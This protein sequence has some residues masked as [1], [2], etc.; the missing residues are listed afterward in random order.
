MAANAISHV[1]TAV[2]LKGRPY[3]TE[4]RAAGFAGLGDHGFPQQ[5]DDRGI[6]SWMAGDRLSH[7]P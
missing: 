1:T 3:S 2:A 4:V 5:F 7:L 6:R